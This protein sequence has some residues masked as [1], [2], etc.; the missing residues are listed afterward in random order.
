[1]LAPC[2]LMGPAPGSAAAQMN[3]RNMVWNDDLKLRL[4]KV[5]C[6]MVACKGHQLP[7]VVG[8]APR[9]ADKCIKGPGN[10]AVCQ[11]PG[12]EPCCQ[13]GWASSWTGEAQ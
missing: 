12:C 13:L 10:A 11:A 4:I 5:R 8:L 7:V 9:L 6:D 3:E 2:L 1:M